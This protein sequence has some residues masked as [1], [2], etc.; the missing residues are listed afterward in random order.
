LVL[1]LSDPACPDG[2]DDGPDGVDLT[3][4]DDSDDDDADDCKISSYRRG[5]AFEV[6]L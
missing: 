6:I 4:P 1:S 3:C 5:H 2:S